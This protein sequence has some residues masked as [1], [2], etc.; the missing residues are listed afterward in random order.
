MRNQS[1]SVLRNYRLGAG[2]LLGLGLVACTDKASTPPVTP[3]PVV[4]VVPVT[5]EEARNYA[6]YSDLVWSDEFD[7]SS[8]DQT[9]WGYDLGGGGWGNNELQSYTNSSDN[10]FVNGGNLT[11][12]ARRQQAGSNAYTSARLLTKNKK[13][14]VYGRIDTRAKIPKGKG[15]WPA[16]WM[17][18][19]D[20]DQNNWPKCG[21]IDIME[22]RGSRPKELLATMHFPD[23]QGARRLKGTTNNVAVDLSE[24][25]HIY[26]VVRSKDQIRMYLDGELYFTFGTADTVGGGYP[27][28]NPFFMILNVAV[29]G[30][31]DGN[32]DASTVF[33]QQMQV[34]YVRY[35]Q[36]K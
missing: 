9:K 17:L 32:P 29:G 18:G 14:F 6:E 12:Q 4:P 5:N 1:I 35:Y 10:S 13:T 2:L 31:F 36:Y 22:L 25:F 24:D 28:N 26:S 7:G 16:I 19:A 21:E 8:L 30:D 34:D 27:F 33:P 23:A 3:P 11:I 15:V 20:I